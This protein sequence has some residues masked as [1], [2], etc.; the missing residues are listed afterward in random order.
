MPRERTIVAFFQEFIPHTD[1]AADNSR[2]RPAES[3]TF[4]QPS[5][6]AAFSVKNAGC[7]C[8]EELIYNPI[9]MLHE[10]ALIINVLP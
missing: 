9:R 5:C 3:D 4:K 2:D 8:V 1:P 7:G 6:A 10:D